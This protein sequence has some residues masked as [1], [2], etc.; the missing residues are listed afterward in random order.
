M[1][2]GGMIGLAPLTCMAGNVTNACADISNVLAGR[3][4]DN[5]SSDHG[6]LRKNKWVITRSP[7]L[8]NP[9]VPL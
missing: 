7:S 4:D 6:A 3:V 5:D 8:K 9:A 2:K 1:P